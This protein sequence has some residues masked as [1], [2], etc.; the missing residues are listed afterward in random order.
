MRNDLNP[1]AKEIG[2]AVHQAEL[3]LSS[4]SKQAQVSGNSIL[5][6]QTDV[7]T[8]QVSTPGPLQVT[9]NTTPAS[10][11]STTYS[12]TGMTTGSIIYWTN[13]NRKQNGDLAPLTENATLDATALAKVNDMFN[14]QYFAHVSP[15]GLSVGTQVTR[16]GY[17]Y[18]MVG[19]N[20]ALGTFDSGKSIVDAWMGR[21]GHRANILQPHYTDIGVGVKQGEYQGNTVWIA[22]QHFGLPHTACPTVDLK[23]K[24][25][26][27]INQTQIS[28][29]K[30]KIDYEKGMIDA[31][32][33][34]YSYEYNQMVDEY[35][36]LIVQ[37]NDLV[38]STKT[39]ISNY[40]NQVTTYNTCVTAVE[41][42]PAPSE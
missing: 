12:A 5:P 6:E 15:T 7:P 35:N 19:E 32:T 28:D 22:V 18:I 29:I 21:P 20:L 1:I 42:T 27:D 17:D 16:A 41:G 30:T 36:A 3:L 4:Q 10:S 23:L 34:H 11:K 38:T 39:D 2:A 26:I 8:Q 40:N 25:Q 33:N 9:A 13:Q 31:A 14:Q 37:Y 24:A